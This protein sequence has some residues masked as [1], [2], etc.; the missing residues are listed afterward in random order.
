VYG[1]R[2]LIFGQILR[3]RVIFPGRGENLFAHLYVEDAARVLVAAAETGWSGTCPVSDDLPVPW[4]EFFAEIRNH[5]PRLREVRIPKWFALAGTTILTPFR[6]LA[7]NPSL[8]TPEAVSVWNAHMSVE[9]GLLW[10]ELGL[11]PKFP[12]VREGI[13]A[14]VEAGVN[15]RWIHSIYDRRG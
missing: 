12:T 4:N 8:S 9:K 3:G 15:L 7:P 5:Y 14:A 13:P 6:R 2:N 10:D 11:K 1:A